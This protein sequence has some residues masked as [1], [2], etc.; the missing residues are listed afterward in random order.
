MRRLFL[1]LLLLLASLAM[2][3]G[4]SQV[5]WKPFTKGMKDASNQK[6]YGFVSIY[7][8]W[9]GYCK[10]LDQTTLKAKPVIQ[11]L[12]KHFV[13]M[14][15]NAESEEQVVWQGEKL[16]A[17]EL[18]G[19]W[20][21]TGFPTLLFFNSKGEMVGSFPSYAD[22]ALMLKLLSYISSGARE[23]NVSFEDYVNQAS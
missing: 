13:S 8:D 12:D 18:V 21:V 17:R 9:C 22:E 23:K 3:Q 2:A 19:L 14:K 4:P 7:T 6:K 16:P 1:P 20:G 11:A 10:K 15:L 5:N